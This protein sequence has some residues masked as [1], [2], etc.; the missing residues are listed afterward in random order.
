MLQDV[1]L[2]QC[3]S[4]PPEFTKILRVILQYLNSLLPYPCTWSSVHN[5]VGVVYSRDVFGTTQWLS[6]VALLLL[7]LLAALGAIGSS[8]C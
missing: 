8:L 3:I 6:P 5:Q 4:I 2:C 7:L 1:M